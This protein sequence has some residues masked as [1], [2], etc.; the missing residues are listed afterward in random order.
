MAG[1]AAGAAAVS[2]WFRAG[3]RAPVPPRD[4]GPTLLLIFALLGLALARLVEVGALAHLPLCA[5]LLFASGFLV[6]AVFAHQGLHHNPEQ[7]P[8]VAPLYAADLLGGCLGSLAASL[9]LIPILG[10]PGT[11]HLA[12]VVALLGSGLDF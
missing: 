8:L 6:A 9:F 7:R 3:D 12:A 2:A 5:A 11:A 10:L 1:L 4:L